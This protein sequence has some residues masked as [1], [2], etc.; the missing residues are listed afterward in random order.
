MPSE[1]P[2][3]FAHD[4]ATFEKALMSLF[5]GSPENAESDL[6]KVFTPTSTMRADD[7]KF[8]FATFV[9]QNRQVRELK[10]KV[11]ITVTQFLR[12][13]KQF[14]D[15]HESTTE[16]LDG[17]FMEAET[18]MF[19]EVAEDGRLAWI[20]ETV[21]HIKRDPIVNTIHLEK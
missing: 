2:T 16:L 11:S 20:V 18:F 10:P 15:R 3:S 21:R 14:A 19:G 17:T 5:S 4:K 9:A 12:D 8:D 6:L 13:G 7:K 1:L